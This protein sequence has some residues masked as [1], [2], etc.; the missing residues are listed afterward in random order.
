MRYA[1]AFADVVT[2]LKLDSVR[3]RQELHSLLEITT[4]SP[5]LR[6]IW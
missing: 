1:R 6:S 4:S 2:G 3:V 5:E